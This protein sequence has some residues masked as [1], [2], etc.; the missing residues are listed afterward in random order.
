MMK[1]IFRPVA[2]IA[3]LFFF[4]SPLFSQDSTSIFPWKVASKKI[5]EGKYAL[6]FSTGPAGDWKLYSPDQINPDL[7]QTTELQ[8]NDSSISQDGK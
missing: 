1:K 6:V 8:F 2:F 4:N 5:E 3:A 7:Q